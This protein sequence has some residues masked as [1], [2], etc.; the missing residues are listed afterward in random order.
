MVCN[1]FSSLNGLNCINGNKKR[2]LNMQRYLCLICLFLLHFK[3]G[4]VV[5]YIVRRCLM[6]IGKYRIK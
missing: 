6:N 3:M 4:D 5:L 2:I 1:T